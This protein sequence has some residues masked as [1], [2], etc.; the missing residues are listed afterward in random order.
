[1]ARV[2]FL[3]FEVEIETLDGETV[4]HAAM[5]AGV[6]INASCGGAGVCNKCRVFVE[7]GRARG[8]SLPEGGYKACTLV[9]ETDLVV[10][11][12][13]E[14][15]LD[16]RALLRAPKRRATAWLAA[17]ARA[18]EI[19]FEPSVKRHYLELPPPDLSDN[20]PDLRRL[21]RGLKEVLGQEPE[22]EWSL[23]SELPYRLRQENFRVTVT[24]YD[25]PER[26]APVV[27]RVHPGKATESLAVAVDVGTTTLCAELV[28]LSSGEVLAETSDYNP[29][30]SYGEDVISR[31]EF[32][33]R[34]GGLKTLA[35]KVRERVAGLIEELGQ[36]T[37][38]ETEEIDLVVLS[39]NTV[40]TH[41]FLALE[42]RFL[43]E[44]P[45]VPVAAFFPPVPAR[46]LG[47]PT[48]EGA[49]AEF[50]PC[51][52]SYVGGDIVSGVV[53]TGFFEE[54]PLTLFIDIGTN[55][56]IV[57]GNRDFLA[58]AACSAGPAFEG[59]GIKHGMRATVGAIEAV[60]LDTET[61][62][63]MILTIGGRKPKGLCGSG[64]IALLS[65]LFLT[66]LIDRSGK[67]RRDLDHPRVREGRDGWEYVLVWA[68]DSATGE[69]IVFTEADIDNLIRA[70]G[71]MFAGYQ[72]LLESVGLSV[73]AVERVILAGNFGSYLDLEQAITIGLLPDLPRDRFF[74]VGNS[75]LLGARLMALSRQMR[76]KAAEVARM[77]THFELSAHP[78]Y[79]DYYMSA[80]FLPHTNI[81]LFPSVKEKLED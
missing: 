5:R 64:I 25:H 79:M 3:P 58:C 4:L 42:P 50:S 27:Q 44:T 70:K 10:R 8:E 40:M 1:M 51:V 52:A 14:S 35:Q 59:G 67:F 7:E 31:I 46:E 75:S 20:L 36:K 45:Y 24:L 23:L 76:E 26:S 11:V 21:K 47:L 2:R 68:E 17:E 34:E 73:E 71:A 48:A 30:I 54:D 15:H 43:R 29:Q 72:T 13:V 63:P 18:R 77:M 22:V 60:H 53:A 78:G 66:G 16:R 19:P 32:A 62:E 38:R 81:E 69:D 9:P 28:D 80:L 74:F 6:H 33:R 57:V 65:Q 56:E 41:L 12:P 39:G 61:Y 55:G 37:G 49:V